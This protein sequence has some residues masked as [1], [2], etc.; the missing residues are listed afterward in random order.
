[1]NQIDMNQIDTYKHM[2]MTKYDKYVQDKQFN[3]E[4]KTFLDLKN[5]NNYQ[6]WLEKW[7]QLQ[8]GQSAK[9]LFKINEVEDDR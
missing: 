4:L 9:D 1:M 3:S 5:H 8:I 6:K 2:L 7:S